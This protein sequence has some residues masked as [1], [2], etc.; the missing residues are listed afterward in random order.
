MHLRI[1]WGAMIAHSCE[2]LSGDGI[3][4]SMPI[5]CRVLVTRISIGAL[6]IYSYIA[7]NATFLF[8][9]SVIPHASFRRRRLLV[10]L[11]RLAL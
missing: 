3:L 1:P 7:L 8:R 10:P 11:L 5:G 9:K 6:I 2:V 4:L